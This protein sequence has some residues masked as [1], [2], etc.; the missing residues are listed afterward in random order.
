MCG[1]TGM[2]DT[3]GRRELDLALLRR[4]N[5]AQAHRGPD[6]RGEHHEPGIALG[7]RRLYKA[8]GSRPAV[9]AA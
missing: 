7:H 5:D 6:G 2:F 8:A 9:T 3:L 1:I 4:M